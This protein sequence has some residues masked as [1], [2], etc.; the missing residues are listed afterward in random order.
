[1]R[2]IQSSFFLALNDLKEP[3]I[4]SLLF[5]PMLLSALF[6]GGLF[7][8]LGNALALRLYELFLIQ[9]GDGIVGVWL[10]WI[11]MISAY[12][13]T[14]LFFLFGV[15]A[16]NLLFASFFTPIACSHVHKQYYAELEVGGFGSLF[17]TIFSLTK[18]T[19]IFCCLWFL[20]IPFYFLPLV[21]PLLALAPLY[22]FFSNMLLYDIGSTVL[23]KEEFRTIVRGKNWHKKTLPLFA[24][25]LIPVVGFFAPLYQI[26]TVAHMLYEE[27]ARYLRSFS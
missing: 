25:G 8:F 2:V 9:T 6:W 1:M 27:K 24:I 13:A 20:C 16:T 21:G 23:T 26:I 22:W 10:G 18:I 15:L 7:L 4:F 5:A 14:G 17:S 11:L 12:L 3:K 19:A